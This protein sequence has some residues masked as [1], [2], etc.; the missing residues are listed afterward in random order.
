MKIIHGVLPGLALLAILLA[1]CD[2]DRPQTGAS[3]PGLDAEPVG[4][5]ATRSDE[6][7]PVPPPRPLVQATVPVK[8][9]SGLSFTDLDKNMDSG[10][11]RAPAHRTHL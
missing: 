6:L 11:S 9:D 2:R 8:P 7:A 4:S 5:S 10:I 1:A 3:D